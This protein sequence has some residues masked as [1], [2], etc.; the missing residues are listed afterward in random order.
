ML[1]IRD[2]RIREID[3]PAGTYKTVT[4]GESHFCAIATDDTITCWGG[5]NEYGEIDAPAGT[6]KTIT[7]FPWA[8][9]RHSNRQHHHMLG[10]LLFRGPRLLRARG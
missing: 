1:G 8:L 10:I 6:Y 9:L 4:V 7:T 3:A 2:R 5:Y